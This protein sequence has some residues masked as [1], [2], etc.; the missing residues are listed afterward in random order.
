MKKTSVTKEKKQAVKKVCMR[1]SGRF[2]SVL[3]LCTLFLCPWQVNG[4]AVSPVVSGNNTDAAHVGKPVT[5]AV[6]MFTGDLMCLKGQQYDAAMRNG[7]YD[8]YPSFRVVAQI[9]KEADYVC[10]NLETLI[11][12]SNPL[13]KDR[14]EE[15]G[16]P[17][18]NGPVAYLDALKKAGFDA[19]ATANNHTCDWGAVGIEETKKYLDEYGFKNVGTRYGA[20]GESGERDEAKDEDRFIICDVKGIKVAVLSYTHLINQRGKMRWEE[21]DGMVNLF[22]REKVKND[23]DDA[24]KAGAEFVAV[25]MHFGTENTEELTSAQINDAEYVAQAGADLIIGSH[26]HCLQ[27]C[28][29]IETSDG[30]EVLCMYSMGNFVSSMARDINNDTLILKIDLVK[31]ENEGKTE[32][33]IKSASYIPCRVTPKFGHSFV[34]MPILRYSDGRCASRSLEEAAQRIAAIIDGVIPERGKKS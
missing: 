3:I 11:S 26:P 30:R 24:K 10:G 16:Q 22:D 31:T 9:F 15:N 19:F 25:Y 28:T 13:T 7:A 27:K 17:Q 21:L 4:A 33:S 12:E 6:C 8:F 18:C 2:L 14:V 5:G 20:Y 34:V 29:Y 1:I 23:I 32:I